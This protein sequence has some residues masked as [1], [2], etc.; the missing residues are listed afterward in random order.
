M[1]TTPPFDKRFDMARRVYSCIGIAPTV[2][3]C[4]GG[5]LTT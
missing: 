5:G 1:I 2:Y 3:C 4:E